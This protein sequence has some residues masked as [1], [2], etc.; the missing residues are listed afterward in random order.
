MTGYGAASADAPTARVAV[1]V[2]GVNQRHLDAKVAL[3]RE[4]AAFEAAVRERVRQAAERGRVDVLVTRLPV[5]ARRRYRVAVRHDLARAY[6]AA[7]RTLARTA[8][9]GGKVTIADVL[10]LP[11]LLEVT[12]E[13]PTL[14][15][16]RRAL[17]RALAKALAAFDRERRREGRHL[18]A[19]LAARVAA[20]RR[21]VVAI[22]SRLPAVR[23]ELEAR[24]G[25]RLA[26]IREAGEVD[27]QR[28]AH[29]VVAFAERGDVSEELVRLDSHLGA[30]AAA[31]RA[32]GAVGKRIEFL[33]QE[34]QRE[35]NTTGAKAA[36]LT[37]NGHVVDAKAEVEK[38]REQV[39]NIE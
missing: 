19:D 21:L 30:L 5:A 26:Q 18:Q 3:P 1:E 39:Q 38:L 27:P 33:L 8:K 37:I 15:P 17:E 29:E 22:R 31:L 28:I 10:H 32:P 2:R 36:D 12:E 4:Y 7:A 11:D 13:P 25:Q 35:L 6:V 16:E 23:A 24:L 20:L 34:V 9:V 14:A